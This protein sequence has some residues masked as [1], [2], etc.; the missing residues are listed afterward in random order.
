MYRYYWLISVCSQKL[1]TRL[2]VLFSWCY[3]DQIWAKLKMNK[4]VNCQFCL[5]LFT[6]CY[7][8]CS[9]KFDAILYSCFAGYALSRVIFTASKSENLFGNPDWYIK[10]LGVYIRLGIQ[11]WEPEN[12]PPP[13]NRT[14][15]LKREASGRE[16][17]GARNITDPKVSSVFKGIPI[18]YFAQYTPFFYVLCPYVEYSG[19]SNK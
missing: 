1:W 3:D 14:Q 4:L 9:R 12:S 11:T 16:N 17:S 8:Y 15:L 13:H 18:F 19:C 5:L 7:F 10:W 2:I 6:I